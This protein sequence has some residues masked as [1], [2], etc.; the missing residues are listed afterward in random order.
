MVKISARKFRKLKIEKNVVVFPLV[1]FRNK[2]DGVPQ[3]VRTVILAH[4][5]KDLAVLEQFSSK[6][7]H[8]VYQEL[9]P[10]QI[11]RKKIKKMEDFRKVHLRQIRWSALNFFACYFF[12]NFKSP[13]KAFSISFTFEASDIHSKSARKIGKLK[14]KNNCDFCW[15]F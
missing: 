5:K 10:R 14:V 8:T 9:P 1:L 12:R 3:I 13:W 4:L 7:A 11:W 6:S 2:Y 15:Y